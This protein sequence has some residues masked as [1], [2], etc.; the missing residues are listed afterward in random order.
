MTG[1]ESD[2]NMK[3]LDT[4]EYISNFQMFASWDFQID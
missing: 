4:K 3:I 1:C 2:I